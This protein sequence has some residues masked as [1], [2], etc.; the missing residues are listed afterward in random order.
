MSNNRILDDLANH[1]SD[2]MRK[3]L[4]DFRER[5]IEVGISEDDMMATIG[6]TLLNASTQFVALMTSLPPDEAG[7]IVSERVKTAREALPSE[8]QD[9]LREHAKQAE[10]RG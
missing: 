1:M 7:R 6:T 9:L 3:V 10:A 4:A 5:C 8:V 2:R